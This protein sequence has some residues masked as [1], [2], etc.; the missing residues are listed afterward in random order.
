MR[1]DLD[2]AL[3]GRIRQILE[4]SGLSRPQFCAAIGVAR[5][6]LANYRAGKRMPDAAFL[7]RVARRFGANPEWLLLGDLPVYRNG[8]TRQ[9][10]LPGG[11]VIQ[12]PA[13]SP[14]AAEPFENF[15][16]LLRDAQASFCFNFGWLAR[17]GA[18]E[19]M[20]VTTVA[21]DD[22]EPLL[23]SGDLLLVDSSRRSPRPGQL[24]VLALGG[25]LVARRIDACVDRLYLRSENPAY[26]RVEVPIAKADML[27]VL[28]RVIWAGKCFLP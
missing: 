18:V 16:A 17:Q 10:P 7:V 27:K 2:A 13:V 21:G 4:E 14:E 11:E 28:G 19:S 15:E 24:F 25:G 23:H 22:M 9:V 1:E 20:F 6:T 26:P 8:F 3:G 5:S 12:V